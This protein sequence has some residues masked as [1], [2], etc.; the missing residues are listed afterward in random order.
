MRPAFEYHCE[1]TT[2]EGFIQQLAVCYVGRGYHL[3]VTGRVPERKDPRA[4]DRKLIER[5]G[6]E[7]SKFVRARRKR[8]GWANLQYIRFERF[9]VI[10][11]ARGLHPIFREEGSGVRDCGQ[12]QPITFGG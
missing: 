11:A 7:V 8:A 12:G 4:V 5:Y 3:Y 10:L 6:I 9:F 2:L 1:A